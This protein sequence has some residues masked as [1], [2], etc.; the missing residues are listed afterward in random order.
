MNEAT[1]SEALDRAALEFSPAMLRATAA[2]PSPLPRA[3]LLIIAILF[4]AMVLWTIFGRLDIVAVAQGK[5]V[6]Q[7]YLKVVQPA[8]SGIVKEILVG[9][10]D[11]VTEGQVLMRMDTQLSDA[12]RKALENEIAMRRLQ[13]RRIDAEL[14]GKAMT[15]V[16]NDQTALYTQIEAQHRARRQSYQDAVDAEREVLAKAQ[17]DLKAAT[18]TES[19]LA[20]TAPLYREQE[21]AWRKLTNEGFAG[22]LY[23]NERERQRIENEQDLKTQQNTV[24]GL[25]SAIAQ[26]E[27]KIAQIT[28]SYR[29]Q[30][31]DER[32]EAGNQLNKLEQ[33][34]AKAEHR[35]GLLE[36]KAPQAGIVKDLVTHTRGTVVQPGT[37]LLTVVPQNEPLLAEVWVT[38][39]D[40][41]FVAPGQDVRL[42]LSAFPFQ[43][44]GMLDG[45]VK[46][47]SADASDSNGNAN[48]SGG[49]RETR[50]AEAASLNYR[51]LVEIKAPEFA[52]ATKIQK[53]SAGMQVS[54]EILLGTRTVLEYLLSPVQKTVHE[55]GR[56][57]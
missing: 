39:L 3:V 45:V 46:H 52:K 14:T 24:Q 38:N 21:E 37:V 43:K 42:K 18:E 29:Q 22:K 55:A 48:A 23:L 50:N 40:S 25:R 54:A 35:H 44:Y 31:Q 32:V 15:R 57:R 1:P 10:G 7:T 17:H 2:P 33:D 4:G 49:G 47:V 20:K 56:E 12:D 26:S 6:P 27:K 41:G 19:K 28:S 5:L 51:A 30:L 34:A 8:D 36:L 53:P 13:V 16:A 9:E 11:V